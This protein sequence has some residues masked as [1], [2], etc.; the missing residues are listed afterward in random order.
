MIKKIILSFVL[1]FISSN[2]GFTEDQK[3]KDIVWLTSAQYPPFNYREENG[4]LQ[5]IAIELI[6]AVMKQLELG[7][8]RTNIETWPWARSYQEA[9]KPGKLNCIFATTRTKEREPLFKWFGPIVKTK[10]SIFGY[11]N[12]I[13]IKDFDDLKNYQY[14]VVQKDI[15]ELTLQTIGVPDAKITRVTKI[16]QLFEMLKLG[17]VDFIAYEENVI[18]FMAN[19]FGYR[20]GEFNSVFT[21]KE[22]ELWYAL[23]RSAND[24]MVRKLQTALNIV[25]KKPSVKKVLKAKYK[26]QLP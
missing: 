5:G 7:K 22:G 26:I 20:D 17:R 21:I 24:E 12:K 8:D 9:L 11:K 4:T 14:V 2:T 18:K 10:I 3:I 15:G 6:E 13:K 16:I 1:I 25:K 23:S 19:K